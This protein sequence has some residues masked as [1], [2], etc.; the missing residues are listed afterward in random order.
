MTTTLTFPGQVPFTD[1][2]V[3]AGGCELG[4]G[5]CMSPAELEITVPAIGSVRLLCRDHA[6][7]FMLAAAGPN[8]RT[9]VR[10]RAL[11]IESGKTE[12]IRT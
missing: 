5:R 2:S 6:G 1:E 11:S 8:R 4:N 12:R 9:Q 7:Y 3:P 10:V